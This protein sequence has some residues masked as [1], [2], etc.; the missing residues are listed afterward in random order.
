M[1]TYQS[2]HTGAEIDAAVDEVSEKLP[3][4][5]GT[6]AGALTIED[7]LTILGS[8]YINNGSAVYI[9]DSNGTNRSLL[10]LSASNNVNIG[11]GTA[12]LGSTY[13][14]GGTT[15]VLRVGGTSSSENVMSFDSEKLAT[16]YGNIKFGNNK[17]VT[18]N[19]TGGTAQNL[20]KLNNS[21]I[22]EIGYTG[23]STNIV[24]SLLLNGNAVVSVLSGSSAPS[25]SLGSD[26]DIYIQT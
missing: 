18:G 14:Y 13:I 6:L 24:G 12:S 8:L 23:G 19:N 10:T 15:I 26:G 7:I 4:T 20:I 16:F 5:G 17:G 11:Y 22:I 3:L 21:N 9:K 25:S 1:A 2:S